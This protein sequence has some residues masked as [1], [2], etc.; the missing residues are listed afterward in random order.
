MRVCFHALVFIWAVAAA[1]LCAGA[2]VKLHCWIVGDTN[3]LIH[4]SA[5][6]SNLVGEVSD[7]YQ[8]VGMPFSVASLTYTNDTRFMAVHLTN[9]VQWT[10][11]CNLTNNTDG[12]E[13][14]FMNAVQGG[15]TAFH[16]PSGIVVGPSAN[17]RT[18]A[19]EIGHACGLPDIY[20][21]HRETPLAVSGAPTKER[22]PEDWGWYPSNVTHKVV[23]S[24]LLM[25]GY[26]SSQKAD[27][28]YG[29]IYGLHYTNSW[30]CVTEKWDKFWELG[31][32]PIG[33]GHH[34]N[35]HPI[36]K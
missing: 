16:I 17:G 21:S 25:Y 34:G 32:V 28:P 15:A 3:N 7:L 8:Q 22:M 14:Y 33:F 29:D 5:S 1:S 27:L 6:V 4:T 12:L 2:P 19:H 24:R 10:V 13:L 36:S 30:N 11:L 18:V 20:D 31:N 35:R 26:L 23:I 9:S